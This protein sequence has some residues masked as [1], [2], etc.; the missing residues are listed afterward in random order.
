ME[1]VLVYSDKGEKLE[2]DLRKAK[3]EV[4]EDQPEVVIAMGGDGTFLE[5]ELMYPGV[6]KIFVRHD[7]KCKR[8]GSHNFSKIIKKFKEGK[9]K[10]SN[11]MKIEAIVN[12]DEKKMIVALN[13]INI[14]YVPPRALRF[15]VAVNRKKI[16][17]YVIGDGLVVAT[18]YGSTAYYNSITRKKFKSGIG[19]AFNNPTEKHKPQVVNE[20]ATIK[21]KVIR[22]D[23][24]VFADCN[25]NGISIKDG[26]EIEIKKA[27]G[28]ANF[29]DLK[30][31][32]RKT[33][34][35]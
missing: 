4:V 19:L 23:G 20:N 10:M 30:G 29:I 34:D 35:Y 1:R 32:Q 16:A 25:P 7:T 2:K 31:M 5:S 14:H 11:E 24:L 21:V 12:G 33:K 6:P 9:Y 18:P 17:N 3:F 8:C 15:E 22:G 13:D 28:M 27:V 26:D